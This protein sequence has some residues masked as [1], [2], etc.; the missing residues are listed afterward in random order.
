MTCIK[1]LA[2]VRFSLLPLVAAATVLSPPGVRAAEPVYLSQT[3]FHRGDDL[4]LMDTPAGRRLAVDNEGNYVLDSSRI[5]RHSRIRV[6]FDSIQKVG[7]AYIMGTIGGYG[8]SSFAKID[9]NAPATIPD[10][11]SKPVFSPGGVQSDADPVRGN[12]GL[13]VFPDDPKG[14]VTQGL[15]LICGQ[16]LNEDSRMFKMVAS[17]DQ[18]APGIPIYRDTKDSVHARDFSDRVFVDHGGK[19]FWYLGGRDGKLAVVHALPGVGAN[20]A[21]TLNLSKIVEI[22]PDSELTFEAGIADNRELWLMLAKEDAGIGGVAAER[23]LFHITRDGGI[24]A[25]TGVTLTRRIPYSR[26][27]LLGDKV[28]LHDWYDLV[29]LDRQ[30]LKPQWRKTVAELVGDKALE[31]RI[32]RAVGQPAGDRLVVGLATPYRKPGETT[33]ALVLDSQGGRKESYVLKPGSIDD[34]VFMHDGGILFFS[35]SYTAKLGG[36]SSVQKK[37]LNSIRRADQDAPAA[38]ADTKRTFAFLK[39]PLAQR[40]KLWLAQPAKDYNGGAML[41][42]NGHLGAM[43][44]G[45]TE[46]ECVNLNVDSMWTGNANQFGSYQGFGQLQF[47]TGHNIKDV[48]DY[49]RELDLRTGIHKVTYTYK[50]TTYR[51]EAF[52]SYPRGLLAIRFTAD[53]PGAYTGELELSSMHTAEMSKDGHGIAFAG[54][55]N[56]GRK[57]KG[58]MRVETKGGKVLPEAGK[59]GVRQETWRRYTAQIPFDG[60]K[61]EGCDS[62]TVYFAGDTDYSLDAKSK[63]VGADPAKKIAP[64][65]AN[66]ESMSFDKMRD[67]SAADVASLFDRCTFELATSKPEAETQPTDRR[68]NN[69]GSDSS[70]A[71]FE[72]LIFAAT[73][74][75]MIA[76]SRPGS[77][78]A[79]LQGLW[80]FSNWPRW[81]S[82][83]H[84]D[85]NVQM[86]YWFVEPANLAECA[87]P[88]FDYIESQI[89]HWRED[90]REV[91]GQKTRGW[92]VCYMHNIDG[93]G[94][95]KNFPPGG[96]WLAWH[97]GEHFKFNQDVAFLKQRAYPLLKELSEHWQDLLI[98]RPGGQLTTPLTFSP[99]HKPEQF[100]ITQDLEMVDNLFADYI[101][102]A[103]RLGTDADF[104]RQVEDL[105]KR[106]TPIQ[107]GRWG[108]IQEWEP[109]RDSRCCTHRHIQH[110]F[111]A[112]PGH[113]ICPEQTPELAAAAVTSL[114]ARGSGSHGWSKAWRMSIFA[115][116]QKPELFYR[117]LRLTPRGFHDTLV[118]EGHQQIDAP[119]GYASGVCEALLQS[120]RTLDERDS[121]YLIH[122]LPA[123]P[124][125]WPTGRVK[126]LRARGGFEVDMEWADGQLIQA[127]IRNVAATEDTCTLRY[128]EKSQKV[129]V[130]R[131]ESLVLQGSIFR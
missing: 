82:D 63:H 101:A 44:T 46:K 59:S 94:T 129:E 118:W 65:L 9:L 32:Y 124:K 120:H 72:A 20:G 126:G 130:G 43:I 30:T 107:I 91:F 86:N 34:M 5:P 48:C 8:R 88:L 24:V 89:P 33:R 75:M 104:K 83:Y 85:I 7:D 37:E 51:R 36:N 97:Y 35:G 100:G 40:Q 102:A 23:T 96:A 28:V 99:E 42:G 62:V 27:A 128:G 64:R 22:G 84:T 90:A 6:N 114:E 98:E 80:N 60:I 15:V 103:K 71:G 109:D 58:V 47:T 25:K 121:Q 95:Y 111:A 10:L 1:R 38:P 26:L 73:R 123:L 31:Y 78:P 14:D 2:G 21:R 39:T 11:L 119:C 116:L 16:S 106:L 52:C 29:A 110:L 117:Q 93:G 115:R 112:F 81:T 113:R 18:A 92:T 70:D 105:Q 56:N 69:Y 76:A 55:L 45:G 74:Y 3:W 49:R 68:L 79:N 13:A 17:G 77:L 66:I 127:V 41:L 19:G 12:P 4:N 125:A 57:F 131:G 122:L 87:E 108:Q 53:K 54:K 67:E 61:L 50:G